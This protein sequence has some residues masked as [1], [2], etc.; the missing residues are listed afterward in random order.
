MPTRTATELIRGDVQ[1]T[2]DASIAKCTVQAM[3]TDQ[4]TRQV[5]VLGTPFLTNRLSA[6]ASPSPPIV[7]V[8]GFGD[9]KTT[10]LAA[11]KR[12]PLLVHLNRRASF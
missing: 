2:P 7:L 8:A 12:N 3:F 1:S 11:N 5:L 9:G 6:A 4:E 10:A